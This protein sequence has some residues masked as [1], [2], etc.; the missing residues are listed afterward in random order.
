ML[1]ALG[2]VRLQP[3]FGTWTWSGRFEFRRHL[4]FFFSSFSDQGAELKTRLTSGSS[5]VMSITG[6][7]S[8]PDEEDCVDMDS[9]RLRTTATSA[10]A[11][12]DLLAFP[13]DTR[14]TFPGK[15]L[16]GR[17]RRRTMSW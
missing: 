9:M 12:D 1:L 2:D 5:P 10:A 4:H 13:L 16:P 11:A 17:R 15:G 3:A 6:M 14:T 8:S 7:L